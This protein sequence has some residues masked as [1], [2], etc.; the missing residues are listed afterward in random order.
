MREVFASAMPSL[1]GWNSIFT[2]YALAAAGLL[3]GLIRGRAPLSR[4]L[5]FPLWTVPFL[6]IAIVIWNLLMLV[7]PVHLDPGLGEILG[8]AFGT[9]FSAACGWGLAETSTDTSHKRGALLDATTDRPPR[10]PLDRDR[11]SL[12]GFPIDPNDETKHFKMIGTTG[13][14]KSTAIRELLEGALE[15]GDRAV[16]ADP[17]CSYVDRFYDRA[18]GDVILNPFEPEPPAGISLPK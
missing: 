16:I 11:L 7:L 13:T 17:D 6:I 10:S 15:R 14:G 8:M 12:A 5:A 9:L 18:R 2:T 1:H 4:I 3:F